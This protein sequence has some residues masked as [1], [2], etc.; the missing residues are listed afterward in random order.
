MST[1]K[2]APYY[3]ELIHKEIASGRYRNEIEVIQA[4]LDLLE[5][6][7]AERKIIEAAL[8][9]GEESGLA[10]PLGIDNFLEEMKMKYTNKKE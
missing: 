1:L 2:V 9:A 8:K 7:H 5:K 3:S 6:E 4:S 10:L